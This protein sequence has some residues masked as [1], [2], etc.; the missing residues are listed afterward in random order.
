MADPCRSGLIDHRLVLGRF[1]V[2]CSIVI[3]LTMLVPAVQPVHAQSL[4]DRVV[5]LLSNNCALLGFGT[6]GGAGFGPNLTSLC[7]IPETGGAGSAG[8]GS[9]SPQG[10]AVSFRTGLLDERLERAKQ[11]RDGDT[12]GS[13]TTAAMLRRDTSNTQYFSMGDSADSASDGSTGRSRRF[14]L[15][16]SAGYGSLDRKETAL[17]TAYD[18]SLV[19]AAVGVDYRFSSKVVGGLLVGYR[20]QDADFAGGGNASIQAVE[21]ILYV[22]VLPSQ[23]TFLQFV[24]GAGS[25]DS[26][27]DRNVAVD[28]VGINGGFDR[29]ATGIAASSVDSTIYSGRALFG[30]DASSGRFTYGPR[31][32]VNVKQLNLDSYVESGTTGVELRVEDRTV[33]SLQAVLGFYG[34]AAY[35][36][37]SGVLVPQVNL[38]YVKEF[39][40]DPNQVRARFVED[41]RDTAAVDFDYLT[42]ALDTE[43]FNLDL[44]LAAVLRNGIQPY[45]NF[46]V[47]IGSDLFDSVVGTAGIRF[48]L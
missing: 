26:D 11:N 16:A 27:I 41:L 20:K 22:S 21:P 4:D 28:I 19:V 15:F 35:S 31:V 2:S 10:S 14:D 18:S 46:R 6:S 3:L 44:G 8:G 25:E 29:Q 17:E 32:A 24:V 39:E 13:T 34:S 47:V 42:N 9:A 37:K 36:I 5:E 45:V 23:R 1:G 40:D 12:G 30:F 7:E 43:F 48:E 33:D 38:E